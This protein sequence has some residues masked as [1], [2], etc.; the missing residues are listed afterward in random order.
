ME[1]KRKTERRGEGGSIDREGE[2][3]ATGWGE[4]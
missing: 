3:E 1:R 2:K 4:L